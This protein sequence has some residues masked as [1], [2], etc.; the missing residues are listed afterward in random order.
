[1][2]KIICWFCGKEIKGKALSSNDKEGLSYHHFFNHEDIKIRL[3]R[4]FGEPRSDKE[5]EARQIQIHLVHRNMP[6]F[7]V[8]IKCHHKLE[9]K[10]K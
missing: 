5:H 9:E 1:M 10:L 3:L 7:P 6:N 8:H 4:L 2:N